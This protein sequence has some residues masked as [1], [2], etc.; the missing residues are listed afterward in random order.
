M[1][2]EMRIDNDR[3]GPEAKS[4]ER[5]PADEPRA[6]IAALVL[7]MHRSGTSAL[8]GVLAR[9]GCA[10]PATE[11]PPDAYNTKGFFE[12][13][14]I[15]G[16][17]NRLLASAGSSW[18]DWTPISADWYAS[19]QREVF[20][21]EARS[22]L[23]QEFGDAPLIALK[24]PRICRLAPFWLQTLR[25]AGFAPRIIHIHRNPGEV[26]ASLEKRN[27][28]D[29]ALSSL[30][31]LRYVLEGEFGSRDEPRTFLTYDQLLA[32]WRSEVVR[33]ERALGSSLPRKSERARAEVNNFLN[34]SMRH[35]EEDPERPRPDAD[36]AE[37]TTAVRSILDRWARE[38]EDEADHAALDAIRTDLDAVAPVFASLTRLAKERRDAQARLTETMTGQET[39]TAQA[40]EAAAAAREETAAVQERAAAVDAR[41]TVVEAKLSKAEADLE[42]REDQFRELTATL[43]SLR[44]DVSHRGE[45]LLET[46]RQLLE[47]CH[48]LA[49]I[50]RSQIDLQRS[51][52]AAKR[53]EADLRKTVTAKY[54]AMFR[55]HMKR[56]GERYHGFGAFRLR[57][58][59]G[60]LKAS[61]L[62]DVDYYLEENKDVRSSGIGA[63]K[64]Y[65]LYGCAEGRDPS[66]GFSTVA[67]YKRNLD[68][69]FSGMNAALHFAKFGRK[70][71]RDVAD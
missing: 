23:K 71:Q 63:E 12:S 8:T 54:D 33:V 38:G 48:E 35:F 55:A 19:L 67:Y 26:A 14:P 64:H 50:S 1:R 59:I 45:L 18:D 31:W 39:E 20:A 42:D 10:A 25:D 22:L 29:P 24:D 11:M 44:H 15:S 7:G 68:V 70:E 27:G 49:E 65:L 3:S 28:F 47:K 16:L 46:E 56:V 4:I 62:F 52:S 34:A 2:D 17:N 69:L 21:E 61:G 66:E 60:A 57:S 51:L 37:W 43:G 5:P 6:R 40:R 58:D 13:K 41:L 53:S 36:V 32:D 30:I 9:L